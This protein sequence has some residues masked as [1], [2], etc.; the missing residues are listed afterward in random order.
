MNASLAPISANL[1]SSED[2][3]I[4]SD[5]KDSTKDQACNRQSLEP[6]HPEL[7]LVSFE[8]LPPPVP[9]PLCLVPH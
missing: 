9:A 4:W 3:L 8:I 1:A 2:Q 7:R 6:T 5:P